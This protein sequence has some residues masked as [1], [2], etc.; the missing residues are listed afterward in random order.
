[1]ELDV[2]AQTLKALVCQLQEGIEAER[3]A[4]ARTLHDELGGLLVATKIDVVWL[5]RR[6]DQGD[7]ESASRWARI[8][9]CLEQGLLFKS[10]IVESLRPTLLDNLGLV[11][12]LAWLMQE[13]LAGKAVQRTE[14]YPEEPAPLD[15]AAGIALFRV[16]QQVLGRIAE[17]IGES[18]DPAVAEARVTLTL[19][20][21]SEG[22]ELEIR[23]DGLRADDARPDGWTAVE[24]AALRQRLM[25]L[26]GSISL[27]AT[28]ATLRL[29][30]KLPGRSRCPVA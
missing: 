22:V 7:P 26:G 10:Q 15:E 9:A 12:A 21:N 4:L 2:D 27:M 30:A 25:P 24:I 5:R 23:G 18:P 28:A 16:A 13:T 19:T 17:R 20:E 14:S 11:A 1:V 3:Q 8:V 29:R 6:L